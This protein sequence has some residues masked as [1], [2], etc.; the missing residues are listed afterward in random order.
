MARKFGSNKYWQQAKKTVEHLYDVEVKID[1]ALLGA[2]D[3][4]IEIS[5]DPQI[6][7]AT[8]LAATKLIIET[9]QKIA[10][11]HGKQPMPKDFTTLSTTYKDTGEPEEVVE[12]DKVIEMKFK[13]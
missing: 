7:A 5:N 2:I 10:K 12:D 1:S 9:H 3:T 8:R 6:S 13:G 11:G 4:I